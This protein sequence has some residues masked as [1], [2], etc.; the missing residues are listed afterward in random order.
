LAVFLAVRA[1]IPAGGSMAF[2]GNI[3]SCFGP[4]RHDVVGTGVRCNRSDIL[5]FRRLNGQ[6]PDSLQRQLGP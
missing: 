1:F 2:S 5:D 3:A 4:R 6:G